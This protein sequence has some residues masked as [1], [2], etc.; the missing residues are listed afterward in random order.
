MNADE[1]WFKLIYAD[2]LS[3]LNADERWFNVIYA[4]FLFAVFIFFTQIYINKKKT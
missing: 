4:D 1:R 3:F 2:F